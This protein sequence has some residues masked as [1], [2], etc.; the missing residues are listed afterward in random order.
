MFQ[1]AVLYNRF[2]M[3]LETMPENDG[4]IPE[5]WTE[6]TEESIPLGENLSKI[7]PR[8]GAEVVLG[9]SFCPVCVYIF[10]QA[11]PYETRLLEPKEETPLP[12]PPRQTEPIDPTEL[13]EQTE[14]TEST[15]KPDR[16]IFLWIGLAVLALLIIGGTAALVVRKI[17]KAGGLPEAFTR[18]LLSGFVST[19]TAVGPD[20]A[21]V[22]DEEA[23]LAEAT[24]AE[25][26]TEKPT[27]NPVQEPE[28]THTIGDTQGSQKDGMLQVY[29]PEGAFLMGAMAAD[30]A[31]AADELPQRSVTLDG[32]WMD[33]TE[34]TNAMFLSFV[35][36]TKY[37]TEAENNGSG[38][39]INNQMQWIKI[40]GA[41]WKA[42]LGPDG[43]DILPDHPVVQVSWKDAEV[44]CSWAGGRLP[45]EAE[46]EKTAR[47]ENGYKYPWG[48]ESVFEGRLNYS[49]IFLNSECFQNQSQELCVFTMPVGSYPDGASPFGALDM[50]GNVWEWVA[51]WY[52]ESSY[53]AA[54]TENPI[55]PQ[56][57]KLRVSR[58]GSWASQPGTVRTSNR[59]AFGPTSATNQDGFRCV[60]PEVP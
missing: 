47:G 15:E 48:N 22:M 59:D 24:P 58:G 3:N 41:Y 13:F 17:N 6:A 49:E 23:D 18:P 54:P 29:V 26:P 28:R 46:W 33:Q 38:M 4:E 16:K 20:S 35:E 55:G 53:Q 1:S 50:A 10:D 57:G 27:Q 14:L 8:C 21:A 39:A 11:T 43:V 31:A 7:C 45:T 5:D 37:K 40:A 32:F 12:D 25:K 42:P 44:Y 56:V 2:I 30:G 34:V 51:D 52:N 60:R 9:L 36:Q 19:E